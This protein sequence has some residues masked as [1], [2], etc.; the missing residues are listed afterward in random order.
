VV[1]ID[2]ARANLG[3]LNYGDDRL[4]DTSVRVPAQLAIALP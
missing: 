1:T 4:T 2:R 3:A